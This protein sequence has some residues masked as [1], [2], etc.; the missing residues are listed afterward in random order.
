[1]PGIAIKYWAFQQTGWGEIVQPPPQPQI[2]PRRGDAD[3]ILY[4]PPNLHDIQ[5][6]LRKLNPITRIDRGFKTIIPFYFYSQ[7]HIEVFSSFLEQIRFYSVLQQTIEMLFFAEN[8]VNLFSQLRPHLETQA[9]PLLIQWPKQ[10][11]TDFT[12]GVSFIQAAN[13]STSWKITNIEAWLKVKSAIQKPIFSEKNRQ[14]YADMKMLLKLAEI[15]WQE[16]PSL[17]SYV[18]NTEKVNFH[19]KTTIFSEKDWNILQSAD[20]KL[21]ISQIIDQMGDFDE[22][23]DIEIEIED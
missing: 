22:N 11:K 19:T 9:K 5:R 3:E 20:M 15:L 10:E 7:S 17:E 6:Q 4:H 1:M 14:I 13:I 18:K 16:K 2:Q 12:L 21:F 23:D 8:S